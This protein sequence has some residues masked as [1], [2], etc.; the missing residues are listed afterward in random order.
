MDSVGETAARIASILDQNKVGSSLEAARLADERL[1][2]MGQ[3]FDGLTHESGSLEVGTVRARIERLAVG[4]GEIT[5]QLQQLEGDKDALVTRLTGEE[6]PA[7]TSMAGTA[8]IHA[9]T[10]SAG[11]SQGVSSYVPDGTSEPRRR[12]MVEYGFAL[13]TDANDSLLDYLGRQP[14]RP[15]P[16]PLPRSYIATEPR[17]AGLCQAIYGLTRMIPSTAE[18]C[19]MGGISEVELDIVDNYALGAGFDDKDFTWLF[20]GGMA[21]T[22]FH[23]LVRAGVVDPRCLETMTLS[24]VAK[25]ITTPWF[26]SLVHDFA[27]TGNGLLQRFGGSMADYEPGMFKRKIDDLALVYKKAHPPEHEPLFEV[28]PAPAGH[29]IRMQNGMYLPS[30]LH[31][32]RPYKVML[33]NYRKTYVND[34]GNGGSA[35][36]PVARRAAVVPS[37]MAAGNPHVARLQEKGTMVARPINDQSG[38]VTLSQESTT[39]DRTL[40]L[41]SRQLVQYEG[42]YGT[43]E[44]LG[45]G[46]LF[47]RR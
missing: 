47:H 1:V 39:I 29:G 25:I 2:E 37:D 34:L 28:R 8:S 17:L 22:V 21:A 4:L 38:R 30:E 11:Q 33:Q 35:G 16:A 23:E 9:P 27:R 6:R 40:A 18:I 46:K 5:S 36:C 42:Q 7:L 31:V 14:V 45:K 13:W 15:A 43:P 24:D 26:S 19:R 3:R 44:V 10:V 32:S 41:I 12:F 20:A